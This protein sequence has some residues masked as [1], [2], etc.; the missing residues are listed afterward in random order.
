VGLAAYVGE[1]WHSWSDV[2]PADDFLCATLT[3]YW[4]TRT[5]T[6]SMRD[7]WDNRW[8]PV[9]RVMSARPRHLV[10][11]RI[12]PFPRGSHRGRIWSACTTFGGG[13]CSHAAGISRRQKSPQPLQ[14]TWLLFSYTIYAEITSVIRAQQAT[15]IPQ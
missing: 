7:Y 10:C 5:I 1:K 11:S 12:K 8:Y 13:Q 2:T 9:D 15:F 3:L 6:S 4:V 14:R